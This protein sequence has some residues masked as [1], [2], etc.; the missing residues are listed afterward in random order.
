MPTRSAEKPV[1]PGQHEGEDVVFVFRHH[2]AF[3]RKPLILGFLGILVAILPMDIP[4]IYSVPWLPSLLLKFALSMVGLV[5]LYWIYNFI[6]WY[7]SVFIVTV[8]RLV[9]I[10]QKGLFKRKVRALFHGRVHALEYTIGGLD[11]VLFHYGSIQVLTEVGNFELKM[12]PN[13][14]ALHERILEVIRNNR[15]RFDDEDHDD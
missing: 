9:E 2:P 8:E 13:P 12:V 3:M 4:L 10:N 14:E 11:A 15:D 1:F 6:K 7:Y 5:F